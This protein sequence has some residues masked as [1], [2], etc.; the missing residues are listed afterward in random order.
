MSQANSQYDVVVIGAGHNGLTAAALLAKSGRKVLVLEQR[1]RVGGMASREPLGN[2]FSAPSVL[3]DTSSVRHELVRALDLQ[4]HGMQLGDAPPAIYVARK[5]DDGLLLHH[6]GSK[7]SDEI[8]RHSKRDAE[9]YPVFRQFIERVR[10]VVNGLLDAPPPAIFG[11]HAGIGPLLRH[12]IAMRR[13]GKRDMTELVRIIPMSAADWLG[14]WFESDLLKAALVGP[15][16]YGAFMGPRSPGSALNLLIWECRKGPLVRGGS[17]AL[18]AALEKAA[19]SHGAEIR[20]RARVA[21]VVTKNGKVLGVAVDG[22]GQIQ[23]STVA[24]SCDPKRTVLELL[25]GSDGAESFRERIRAFRS[26]GT[27]A[28][29]NLALKTRVALAPGRND[30]VEI[31]RTAAG[32][33]EIERAFDPIKYGRCSERPLLDVFAPCASD[34]SCA[35]DGCSVL[36]VLAHF[37]PHQLSGGWDESRRAALGKNVVEILSGLIP[38]VQGAVGAIDVLTPVDLEKKY[39]AT[40]GHIFHGEH[41]VDQLLVRPSP[42]CARYETPIEGLYLC[43]SGSHGGGGLTCAPGALGAAAILS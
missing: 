32:L 27:T 10:G 33:D 42:E 21:A 25:P 4:R 41:S 26:R 6:D 3:H 35:P 40:Q 17:S 20:T 13:L 22:G 16:V 14:E 34:P 12:A 24:A 37:V 23:S 39:G 31:M 29:I 5:D 38:G 19:L 11:E 8:G 30:V 18:V 15:A 7:A 36:S 28:K 1:E 2:G 9:Q 43:G